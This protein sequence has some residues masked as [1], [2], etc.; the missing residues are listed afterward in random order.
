MKNHARVKDLLITY[1]KTSLPGVILY[2]EDK[3]L[4]I[5]DNTWIKKIKDLLTNKNYESAEA[6]IASLLHTF[7]L[8]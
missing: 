6:E 3:D 2:L 4:I 7:K 8:T 5:D 1:E